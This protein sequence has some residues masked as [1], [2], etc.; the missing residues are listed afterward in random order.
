MASISRD[1]T[2]A[3]QGSGNT[4]RWGKG[5]GLVGQRYAGPNNTE[6]TVMYLIL[7]IILEMVGYGVLRYVFRGV[8]GG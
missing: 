8:H 1:A 6:P 2:T 3:P 7:L 4:G 5:F